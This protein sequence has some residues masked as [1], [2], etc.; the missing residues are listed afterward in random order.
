MCALKQNLHTLKGNA[1][2]MEL[3]VLAQLCHAAE[4][5]LAGEGSTEDVM[6]PIMRRWNELRATLELLGATDAVDR[7]EVSRQ[8]L[9]QVIGALEQGRPL[10]Q[11]IATLRC[12]KLEPL[13]L[14]LTRLG[15]HARGLAQRLGK[16][17][18]RVE[19]AADGLLFDPTSEVGFWK[20][21][22]HVVRNAVDHGME[23]PSGRQA[24]GKELPELRLEA[25]L[26]GDDLTL[27]I[28]DDGGGIDW[29]R[30]A[31][32]AQ[33]KGLALGNHSD[34]IQALLVPELSTRSEVSD[35]SGRGVGMAALASH[36]ERLGGSIDAESTVG[37]GC[38]WTIIVPAAPLGVQSTAPESERR[39]LSNTP[40]REAV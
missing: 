29:E 15:E 31:G 34:L 1:G 38:T 11:I 22:V 36:I 28:Q 39:L 3:T 10:P 17:D 5:A 30:V 33:Q 6:K 24:A 35:T 23:L 4:D 20:S 16:G 19:V 9:S 32:V 40:E 18:I 25:E 14:P 27:R 37:H 7:L 21:L 12:W 26:Q 8:E 13:Q 2:M